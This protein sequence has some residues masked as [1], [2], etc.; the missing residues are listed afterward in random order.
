MKKILVILTISLAF[1]A[2]NKTNK[3]VVLTYPD[4][5]P[6]LVY[7][8]QGK[9]ADKVLV[10]EENFYENGQMRY[11]KEYNEGKPTKMWKF[12]YES[13]KAFATADYGDTQ[14]EPYWKFY[15]EEG[16]TLAQ[17]S[18]SI[19]ILEINS[20]YSPANIL[21]GK[22]KYEQTQYQFFTNFKMR[23][24]GNLNDGNRDGRWVM[25]FPNGNKQTECSYSNGVAQG[26]QVVYFENGN[27]RY[28]GSFYNGLRIGE[29]QF[30]DENGNLVSSKVF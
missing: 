3:E 13:G 28:K 8:T 17:S 18:D 6:Q 22:N 11:S 1:F 9:D 30:F 21:C 27:V 24:K 14:K 12:F 10:K 5:K 20:D 16:N 7:Y 19:V 25:W 15:D 26:E 4:G 23:S 29:W 2:C